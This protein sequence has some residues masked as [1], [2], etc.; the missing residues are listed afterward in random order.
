MT[1]WA[2]DLIAVYLLVRWAGIRVAEDESG[3]VGIKIVPLFETIADLQAALSIL[4]ELFSTPFVRR[5]VAQLGNVQEVM[6]GYSDSN[7]D[8]GFLASNWELSKAQKRIA[9]V[10]EK[11]GLRIVFSTVAVV[12]SAGVERRQAAPLLPNPREQSRAQCG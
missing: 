1:R 9:K 12:R 3:T 4:S 5:S 2:D 10:G 11:Y 8:G 7:K 6:L